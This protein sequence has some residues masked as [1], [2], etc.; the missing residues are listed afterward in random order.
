MIAAASL[1]ACKDKA[2]PE[3]DTCERK[4][5]EGNV[6]EAEMACMQAVNRDPNSA[7]GKAAASKLPALHEA[8]GAARAAV[9]KKEAEDEAR[10]IEVDCKDVLRA[11]L[12]DASASNVRFVNKRIVTSAKIESTEWV[13]KGN[14]TLCQVGSDVEGQ[15]AGILCSL[16]PATPNEVK[17]RLKAGDTVKVAGRVEKF[18]RA[19]ISLGAMAQLTI[20]P[21]EIVE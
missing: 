18:F 10:G 16:D 17:A 19:D 12:A 3:F 8:V 11:F 14:V 21:C 13:R 5:A 20:K 2:K 4:L 15:S 6:E 9:R 7:S 1:V